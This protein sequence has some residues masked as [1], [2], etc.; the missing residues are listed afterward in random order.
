MPTY[1][2]K[3]LGAPGQTTNEGR[4]S[5]GV[6][7]ASDEYPN[8]VV[9]TNS[10]GTIINRMQADNG[11]ICYVYISDT[12][13]NNVR[14]I[15][16]H[17]FYDNGSTWGPS[18]TVN[19]NLTNLTGKSLAVGYRAPGGICD[20]WNACTLTIYT[21][22]NTYTITITN[23]TGGTVTASATSGIRKGATITLYRTASTGYQFS[24]WGASVTVNS[25]NQFSMPAANVTVS[26]TWTKI[27]YT[28][29]KA[30]NPSGAGTLTAPATATY[31]ATVTLSQTPSAQTWQFSNYTVS[32]I[33]TISGN[34]FTMPAQNVTVT[35]NYV[36]VAHT[37]TWTTTSSLSVIQSGRWLTF[38]MTGTATENYGAAVTYYL[39]K[40]EDTSS[41]AQA[42]TFV[43]NVA[44]LRLEDSDNGQER[45]YRIMAYSTSNLSIDG[46]SL[47]YTASFVVPVYE[48]GYYNNDNEQQEFEFTR[49]I[50]YYYDGTNW[51]ECVV[52]YRIATNEWQRVT[53]F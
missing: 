53:S 7:L 30:V 33:G 32:S 22:Y 29:T 10:G 34:T 12:S 17:T 27:N 24:S 37:L 25:S 40:G 3:L 8:K 9:L 49:C 45:A 5:I 11:Y 20:M 31:G 6:T 42:A 41:M 50:P 2:N 18:G 19:A 15:C 43:N 39:M 23:H 51:R 14:D 47:T 36:N 46:A 26:P 1:G 38:R 4:Y 21:T 35:A 44:V 13:G 48:G 28:I 16:S 52:S